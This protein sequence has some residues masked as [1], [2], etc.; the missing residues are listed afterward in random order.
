MHKKDQAL[1]NV[2]KQVFLQHAVPNHGY[3]SKH[4]TLF[5]QKQII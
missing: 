1:K 5:L 2:R 4:T 3:N